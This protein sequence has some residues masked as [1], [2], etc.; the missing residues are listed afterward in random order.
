MRPSL[1]GS[2]GFPPPPPPSGGDARGGGAPSSSP[3]ASGQGG[4]RM[5]K[6]PAPQTG[7]RRGRGP[8]KA[9]G[10]RGGGPGTATR[11]RV[12]PG[13]ASPRP[14]ES[15]GGCGGRRPSARTTRCC[16]P[17]ANLGQKDRAWE[18]PADRG[19]W[20]GRGGHGPQPPSGWPRS[21]PEAGGVRGGMLQVPGPLLPC[22]PAAQPPHLS[23]ARASARA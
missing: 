7:Q 22:A 13:P 19:S 5:R 6:H 1:A 20:R 23:K 4:R 18:V 8:G 15:G 12:G 11:C 3:S 2:A 17:A 10:W 21:A 16:G 9:P 14:P